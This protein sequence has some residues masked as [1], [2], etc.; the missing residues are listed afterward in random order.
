LIHSY[1]GLLVTRGSKLALLKSTFN[2]ENFKFAGC[3]G[4]SPVIWMQLT[5]EMYVAAS[6]RENI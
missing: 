4:L 2:A 3:L 5:L 6:N 1:G